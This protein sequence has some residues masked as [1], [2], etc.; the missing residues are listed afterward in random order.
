MGEGVTFN[1]VGL[2]EVLWDLLPTG[3]QLG[4]APANFTC[5]AAALGARAMIVTRVGDD[6]LGKEVLRRFAQMNLP[7]E[8]VQ[9]DLARPTGTVAVSLG[10]NG[11]ASY[12]F[13]ENAAWDQ[14]APTNAALETIRGVH[15]V[16]FG[17]LGQRNATSRRTIQQLVAAAPADALKIF[18]INLR[19]DFYSRE[20]IE[21]SMRLSNVLKLNDDEL[22]V[23]T[24]MFSLHGDVRQRL[25]WLI[26]EFQFKVVVLT[27]GASGSLIHQQGHWSQLPPHPVEVVDTVG[28]GDAFTAALTLGLLTRMNLEEL[29]VIAA[30]VARYICSQRGAIPALPER[31]RKQFQLDERR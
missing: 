2:G 29:H 18:D 3:P 11:V 9:V 10:E 28:A 7:R 23:L 1:V 8:S 26:R 21:E 4:G 16:C 17:T 6:D 22:A 12:S 24:R 27:R 30:E 13:A 31:F 14:L 25:E 15:A 5:Q 20:L 19:L